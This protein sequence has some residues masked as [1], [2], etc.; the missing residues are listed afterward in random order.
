MFC[1][2]NPVG[3]PVDRKNTVC[4]WSSEADSNKVSNQMA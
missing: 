2:G 3:H 4:K 1:G